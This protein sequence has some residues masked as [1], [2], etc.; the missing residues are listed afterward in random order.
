[1]A[2]RFDSPLDIRERRRRRRRNRDKDWFGQ[3]SEKFAKFMGTPRFIAYM[4]IFVFCWITFNLVALNAWKF[5]PYPFILLNLM[6]ST[7]A[8]YAAPLIL[9][10][11]NRQDDRDRVVAEQDRRRAERN[12]ADTEFLTREIESLRFAVSEVATR[13]YIRSELRSLL[14]ELKEDDTDLVAERDELINELRE[15]ISR[16]R[17][18]QN[19]SNSFS[20]NADKKDSNIEK[21]QSTCTVK[22]ENEYQDS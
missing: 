21:S 15:E 16:L 5:D 19:Q 3:F 4:T 22:N 18:V 1:M 9:L 6:F 14:E 20:K 11:Q 7:Q 13:D 2:D 8:S 10:A 17:A 12:L